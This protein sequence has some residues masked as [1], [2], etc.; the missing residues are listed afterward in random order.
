MIIY[1][2]TFQLESAVH[3]FYIDELLSSIYYVTRSLVHIFYY[4]PYDICK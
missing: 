1:M 2:I 4:A 3:Y